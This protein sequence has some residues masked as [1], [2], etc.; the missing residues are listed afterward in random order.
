M[1]Q[2]TKVTGKE[3]T[4]LIIHIVHGNQKNCSSKKGS[5]RPEEDAGRIDT[6]ESPGL[7][8]RKRRKHYSLSMRRRGGIWPMEVADD[9]S[10]R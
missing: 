8:T 3:I 7:V 9:R 5:W 4:S 2:H 1:K 10:E 6:R